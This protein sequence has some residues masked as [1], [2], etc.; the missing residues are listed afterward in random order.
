MNLPQTIT[1]GISSCLLGQEVRFD[2][3]HKN[4]PF[5]SKELSRH[6]EF[7]PVCPEMAVGLGTPRPTLRL[8]QSAQD[9]I[10]VRRS[11]D[12]SIDVT[13][14]LAAVADKTVTDAPYISGYV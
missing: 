8:V 2:G 7:Y 12:N 4:L 5:A 9:T 11:E 3:G 1:L 6:F 14:E 13:D 10:R